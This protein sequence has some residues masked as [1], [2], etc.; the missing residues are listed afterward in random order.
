MRNKQNLMRDDLSSKLIHFTRNNNKF[1]A[2]ESFRRIIQEKTIRGGRGYVK[3]GFDCVSF[4]ETPVSKIAYIMAQENRSGIR[5]EPFGIMYDKLTMFK[6]GARPVIYQ[7]ENEYSDLTDNQK[8]R[9]VKFE[10]DY[11]VKKST[12]YTWEREWR[13]KTK[14]LK[15]NPEEVTLIV[16]TRKCVEI[17]KEQN[18]AENQYAAMSGFPQYVD[19]LQW[20]FL[21]LDDLGF[22]ILS[23]L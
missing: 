7:S 14:K 19:K 23:K 6:K 12:D 22:D 4:T 10:L 1:S 11:D 2:I 20:H 13:I 9:H 21:V 3:G 18:N 5:Y 16:P 17:I 8:Y 15:I